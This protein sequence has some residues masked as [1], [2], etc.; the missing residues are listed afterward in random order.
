MKTAEEIAIN[1][2]CENHPMASTTM[3]TCCLIGL[4]REGLTEGRKSMAVYILELC[5]KAIDSGAGPSAFELEED[6]RKIVEDF[7]FVKSEARP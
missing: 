4:A 1:Y 6:I 7:K 2:M 5:K 3:G